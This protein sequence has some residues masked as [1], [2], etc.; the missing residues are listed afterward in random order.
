MSSRYTGPEEGQGEHPFDALIRQALK[1]GKINCV[2][3]PLD[4][5]SIE[6]PDEGVE[7]SQIGLAKLPDYLTVPE[8]LHEL[9]LCGFRPATL[10]E[11]LRFIVEVWDGQEEP[12]SIPPFFYHPA[13]QEGR[14]VC[15]F[16][17]SGWLGVASTTGN[18]WSGIWT[19]VVPLGV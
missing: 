12:L 17:S 5:T 1:L 2:D 13:G 15:G 4:S 10:L 14:E 8:Q 6:E 11:S 7:S 9:K 19:I 3:P 18:E 16:V